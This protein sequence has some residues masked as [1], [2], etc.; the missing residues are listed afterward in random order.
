MA[1]PGCWKSQERQRKSTR[2]EKKQKV[3]ALTTQYHDTPNKNGVVDRYPYFLLS[4]LARAEALPKPLG[5]NTW[6]V[7]IK[8]R[9][10]VLYY[11]TCMEQ[12]TIPPWLRRSWESSG[13][14]CTEWY[15]PF[16]G[17]GAP[18]C[19]TFLGDNEP[20]YRLRLTQLVPPPARSL[21]IVFTMGIFDNDVLDRVLSGLRRFAFDEG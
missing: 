21:T 14:A 19:C 17:S 4:I 10:P 5:W 3:A 9:G 2:V 18:D 11:Y 6:S 13:L 8:G 7:R 16:F 15:C 12:D 1:L 20:M